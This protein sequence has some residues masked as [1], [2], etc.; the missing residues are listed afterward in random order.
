MFNDQTK[1]T[2]ITNWT[3][4]G[5]KTI[6]EGGEVGYQYRKSGTT[7]D[8]DPL[9]RQNVLN[10]SS[11]VSDRTTNNLVIVEPTHPIFTTP[12]AITGPITVNN[13]GSS[14]WGAR[15]EMTLLNKPGVIRVANWT[16]NNSSS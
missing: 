13:G 3:L 8:R 4:A 1:R 12:N 2:A 14:G 16:C 5:G 10:D 7:T 15:D 9:F 11:W 6:V